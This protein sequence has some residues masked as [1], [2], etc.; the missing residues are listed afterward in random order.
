MSD[1]ETANLKMEDRRR[2]RNKKIFED[3]GARVRAK[4]SAKEGE[5]G[6]IRRVRATVTEMVARGSGPIPHKLRE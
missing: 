6:M 4:D 2:M 3:G 1:K 5:V